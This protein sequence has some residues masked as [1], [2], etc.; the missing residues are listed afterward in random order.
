MQDKS[1][2][3]VWNF[4]DPAHTGLPR[5]LQRLLNTMGLIALVAPYLVVLIPCFFMVW[6]A[7]EL[8]TIFAL[9]AWG[10]FAALMAMIKVGATMC[11]IEMLFTVYCFRH[12]YAEGLRS[13]VYEACEEFFYPWL[14]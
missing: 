7:N 13:I 14:H 9:T 10:A 4:I 1:L 3:P 12:E 6:A 11:A 2:K 5:S 8:Q